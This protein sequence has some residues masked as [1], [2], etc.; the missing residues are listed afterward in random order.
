MGIHSRRWLICL[1]VLAVSS[2]AMAGDRPWRA[3]ATPHYRLISQLSE[4]DT[5]VWMREFDQFIL[6]TTDILKMDVRALP[7]LTVV[8]FDRDKEY[9]PYKLLR[10]NG[11]TADVAG[12]FVWRPTW[13]MIGMANATATEASR[14]TIY[15]EAMHWLMS[16][17]QARHPAWFS[18]GIA[19]MF[20]TFERRGDKV[21][22]AKPISSHLALLQTTRD[23]PLAEF[24]IEPAA[25]FDRDER[26]DRFYAQAWAFTHFLM[27]STGRRE[28]LLKFLETYKVK[29]GEATVEAVF[30]TTLKDTEREFRLYVEQRSWGYTIRP[31][32]AAAE[33]PALQPAPPA[34]VDAS[35]GFLALG[36]RRHDLAR[37][38]ARKAIALDDNVPDGHA[39]L[40][41]LAVDEDNDFDQAVTHARA[42]LARGSKDSSLFMLLGDSY[43]KGRNSQQP[44]AKR[45]RVDMYENAI[46]LTPRRLAGYERLTEA[47]FALENPREEDAQFLI[48]GL[49]VF[50]GEDWLRVGTAVVDYRRGRREAAMTTIE[51]VSRPESTLDGA[52]RAYAA[53]LRR[54]W[55][56]DAMRSEVQ[57]ATDKRDFAGARAV[58]SRYRERIGKD[59]DVDVYLDELDA[60]LERGQKSMRGGR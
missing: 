55:L 47:L 23:L 34:L 54:S 29:S 38:H 26:T 36:A 11:E 18:E 30:G 59:P 32:K 39:I 41:Y 25:L 2:P 1:L 27:F 6:S 46:N 15:H 10:P 4:R 37:A 3:A 35:L 56:I 31:V 17:D 43:M 49:R 12:Q 48:L 13:S 51:T 40:A 16:V 50:P 33:P 57:A 19:E 44:D 42:A 24:L 28:Q 7:P 52:Q 21:N 53:G 20:S 58:V 60:G 8:L 5:A 22:W 9:T 45:A 14:R